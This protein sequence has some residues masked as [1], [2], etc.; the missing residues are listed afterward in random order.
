VVGVPYTLRK[1]EAIISK[2]H[3]RFKR[4]FGIELPN[5]FKEALTLDRRNGNDYWEKAIKKEMNARLF[6]TLKI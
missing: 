1:R 2:V 6:L 3:S 4:E 5:T